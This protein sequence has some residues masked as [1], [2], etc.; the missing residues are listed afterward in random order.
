MI[1]QQQ[2]TIIYNRINLVHR[3]FEL[4]QNEI[5]DTPPL[6]DRQ[7]LFNSLNDDLNEYS[8]GIDLR[9]TLPQADFITFMNEVQIAC[10]DFEKELLTV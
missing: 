9:I 5:I 1:V 4:K 10:V 6:G 7:L 2:R 8:D 3:A